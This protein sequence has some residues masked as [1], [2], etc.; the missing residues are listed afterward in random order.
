MPTFTSEPLI[1]LETNGK[2]PDELAIDVSGQERCTYSARGKVQAGPDSLCVQNPFQPLHPVPV[3]QEKGEVVRD[4]G[5]MRRH[6]RFLVFNFEWPQYE[7]HGHD[8]MRGPQRR[9]YRWGLVTTRTL[10]RYSSRL[11]AWEP[12]TGEATTYL[13]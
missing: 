6:C 2:P 10:D 9:L 12:S 5:T 3:T 1:E 11:R 8:G 13:A 7:G 4:E